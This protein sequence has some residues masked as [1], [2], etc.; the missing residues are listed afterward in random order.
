MTVSP[1]DLADRPSA[2]DGDDAPG[3]AGQPLDLLSELLRT[4]RLSGERVAVHAPPR[5]FSHD[6]ADVGSLLFID[7]GEL[8]LRIEGEPHVQHVRCGDVVLLPRGDRHQLSDIATAADE[9]PA[10]WLSG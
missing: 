5:R 8:A 10:R 6:V 9:R 3:R 4:V 2:V 7:E 1:E